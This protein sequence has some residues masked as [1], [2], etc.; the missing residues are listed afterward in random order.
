M[1]HRPNRAALLVLP[2]LIFLSAT[3]IYPLIGLFLRSMDPEGRLSFTAPRFALLN[4]AGLLSDP[5]YQVIL[6][7]TFIVAAVATVVTLVLAYPVCYFMSR[8]PGRWAKVLLILALFPFWTSILVRL[9]AFT[10]I[11]PHF[12][13]MYTTT[14]TVI[15]MVYY[16]LPYM[17][18]VL[19]ATMVGIDNELIN[20]ARTLGANMRQAMLRIFMP[21]TK[22]GVAVGSTMVF[23]ISLGFFLTP[24]LLGG[25]SDLTV[26]TYIQQQVNIAKWGRASAMGTVLLVLTL[27]AYYGFNRLFGSDKG[28]ILGGGSQKGVSRTE[29]LR[30]TWPV[31]SGFVL[32]IAVF[33]FLLAPLVI[34]V[35]LSFTSTT[36]LSF[37]PKG[38][39]GRWY[40]GFFTD[41]DWLGSAWLSLKVAA[42]TAVTATI[43]GLLTAIGLVRGNLPFQRFMSAMFLAPLIVPVILIA[44]SL[45]DIANRFH[46]VGTLTG[47]VAGHALLALPVTVLIASNA[48]RSI[49]TELELAARTL[50]ASRVRAFLSVT[51]RMIAPSLAVAAIFAFVTS[52]DEPVVALF[53]STGRS[54]LP[55]HI[56]NHIQTEVSPMVAAVSTMLMAVVLLGGLFYALVSALRRRR[57]QAGFG[58]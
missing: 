50:G 8:L 26:S 1:R 40:T 58:G 43:L 12:G 31:A 32:T 27:V 39:S 38:F 18:A 54:T 36:Y 21:L 55:V 35:L 10:Q 16:L 25:G 20:A 34:V 6:K 19:Y 44:V 9:F 13:V 7:N 41:R 56:F 14:A 52:W 29:G 3:F 57:L 46:L 37:P 5:L 2:G 42:L 11:L 45:F 47:Y 4:Y 17:I 33:A 48:L 51:A 15:G 24:A 23:V 53:M 28:G 30:M 22:P 49:G